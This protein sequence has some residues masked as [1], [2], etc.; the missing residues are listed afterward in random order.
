M[1]HPWAEVA[2]PQASIRYASHLQKSPRNHDCN[3]QSGGGPGVPGTATSL[4]HRSTAS[5]LCCNCGTIV[6]L[7]KQLLTYK[8]PT[9][10]SCLWFC[11]FEASIIQGSKAQTRHLY[12]KTTWST[13]VME[14]V[15]PKLAPSQSNIELTR[16]HSVSSSLP[17]ISTEGVAL[18]NYGHFQ[19]GIW[20]FFSNSVLPYSETPN[21]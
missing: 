8:V 2:I 3:C 15:N 17:E 11:H 20:D 4:Q 1:P 10:P 5:S 13:A 7:I 21:P 18:A 12:P 19:L 6:Q 16:T 14:S 9:Q